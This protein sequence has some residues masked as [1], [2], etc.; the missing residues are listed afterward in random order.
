MADAR[1][2]CDVV[3]VGGGVYGASVLFHLAKLGIEAML[4][5]R[6]SLASGPT[7]RSSGNVRLHYVTPELAEIAWLSWQVMDRFADEVG[8]DNGFMRVGVL[9]A[10]AADDAPI[11]EANVRRLVGRGEPIETCSPR[12][13][14]ERIPGVRLDGI[15][16]GVW[17][18]RS[19]YA[20]PVGTTLG[21]CEAARRLGAEIRTNTAVGRLL[22]E[23]G[24]A[25][26]IELVDGSRLAANRIVVA[27]GPWSKELLATAGIDLPTCP[28]RHAVT[29][30]SA[31]DRARW[32]V[33]CVFSDRL[34]RYYARPEGESLVLL[35]GPTSLTLPVGPAELGDA[36]LADPTVSV[37]ESAEHVERATRR[38]PA[39]DGL[40]IRPG[41]ASIYDMSPDHFPIVDAVP[42]IEG[43]Y[44]AAG[45]SGHGFKLAPALGSLLADLVA[46]RRSGLLE[47]FRFDR[48]FGPTGEISA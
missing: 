34:N 38:I 26:G 21:F 35:G 9:Y 33:P 2:S 12:E 42:G 44:V 47:P 15:A 14:G 8:G 4:V 1:K 41:Y 6:T 37:E 30:L 48:S 28:E 3:V 45:T 11:F 5:E 46:G 10:V 22:V 18:P 27:A 13:V 7:G 31:P 40:G 24:R 20:D 36:D 19:G 17:E 25:R 39:L 23:D 29:L 32:F 43:L 16:L